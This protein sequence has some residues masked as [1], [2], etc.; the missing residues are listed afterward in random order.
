MLKRTAF[1]CALLFGAFWLPS[2]PDAHAAGITLRGASDCVLW[3]KGRAHNDASYEKA[4][5]A[6]YFTGLA[7]G[8]DVNFWGTRGKD[9]LESEAV[10]KWMDEYCAANPK[11]SLLKGAEKLF[12]ER[13]QRTAK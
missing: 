13:L 10:W 5:L 1:I 11:N 12:L 4:W 2:A 9:E 3:A 6:G 7:I 8:F